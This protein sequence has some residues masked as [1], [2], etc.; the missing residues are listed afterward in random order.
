M[1]W[2]LFAVTFGAVFL[3]ELGDKTQL[4]LMAFAGDSR[5]P[6]V[7]FAASAIA[8]VAA[9]ATGVAAGTLLSRWI[10]PASMRRGA[11]VLFVLIGAWML[12]REFRAGKY[13]DPTVRLGRVWPGRPRETAP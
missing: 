12:F 7:V 13:E 10:S 4:A 2:K 1:D 3:A 11:A 9:A 6:W 5:K 8:L